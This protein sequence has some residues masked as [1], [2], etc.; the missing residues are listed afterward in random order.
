M[1]NNILKIQKEMFLKKTFIKYEIKKIIL[2]SITQ[3]NN[4][5]P[6]Y[7][8]NALYKLSKLIKKMGISKNNNI[9]LKS[10]RSKGVYKLTNFSR[11]YM[12]TL[13]IQNNLQNIKIS[14]W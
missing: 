8:A 6:I 13:F 2:K 11:H 1:K 10:G 7:R 3:N 4:V 5:K 14:K 9:C 12:R